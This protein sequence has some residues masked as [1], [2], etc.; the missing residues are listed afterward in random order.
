[1]RILS[2]SGLQ[3][4]N[5]SKDMPQPPPSLSFH[6]RSAASKFPEIDSFL[7]QWISSNTNASSSA[8]ISIK[9]VSCFP[10]TLVYNVAGS[11]FCFRMGREHKSNGVY[12]VVELNRGV[13]TVSM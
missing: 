2:Y 7:V 8:S 3:A 4:G 13:F 1:M 6:V 10:E 11:R 5:V 9:S 12:Y